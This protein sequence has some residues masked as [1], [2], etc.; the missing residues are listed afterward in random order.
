MFESLKFP[1]A[2]R[3]QFL[4]LHQENLG[5][6]NLCDHTLWTMHENPCTVEEDNENDKK[7]KLPKL[8]K[9]CKKIKNKERFCNQ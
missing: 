2:F 7:T 8:T 5:S 3:K 1:A 6:G 4:A 9:S